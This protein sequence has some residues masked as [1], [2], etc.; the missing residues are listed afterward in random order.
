MHAQQASC[1]GRCQNG[2]SEFPLSAALTTHGKYDSHYVSDRVLEQFL[3][4]PLCFNS[5]F[6]ANQEAVG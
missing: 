4:V 5:F 2:F 3:A 1:Y 6:F